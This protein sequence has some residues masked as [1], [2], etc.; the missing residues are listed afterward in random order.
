MYPN[1]P[2]EAN[3]SNNP[4]NLGILGEVPTLLASSLS[5]KSKF[6][7]RNL[8]RY[9]IVLNTGEEDKRKQLTLTDS[10]KRSVKDH[11]QNIMR[12]ANNSNV[13]DRSTMGNINERGIMNY[14]MSDMLALWEIK[15]L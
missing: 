11:D 10:G 9:S 12:D 2:L 1:L 6:S 5:L 3:C 8:A 13:V 4:M 14:G 7:K 15:T